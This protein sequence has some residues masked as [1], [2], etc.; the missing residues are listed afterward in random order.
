MFSIE[1]GNFLNN[2][3]SFGFNTAKQFFLFLHV[4]DYQGPF[5]H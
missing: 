3:L 5:E 1:F 4:F 2:S